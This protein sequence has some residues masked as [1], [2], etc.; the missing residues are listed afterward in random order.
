[1]A[2]P[3]ARPHPAR[4]PPDRGSLRSVP[5]WDGTYRASPGGLKRTP[6]VQAVQA[7]GAASRS[8][9][10]PA[11]RRSTYSTSLAADSSGDS[12]SV[13]RVSSAA[14]GSSYGSDTPEKP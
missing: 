4:S 14:S 11:K 6:S 3:A 12:D 2:P 10:D 5:L 9:P 13:S 1:M 8:V 7:L